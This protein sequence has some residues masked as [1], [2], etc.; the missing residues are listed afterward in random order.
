MAIHLETNLEGDFLVAKATG[1]D[2][3]LEEVQQYAS[4]VIEAARKSG[5]KKVLCDETELVYTIG[6]VDIYDL[7]KFISQHAP[8]VAR[9]AL[10][11]NP[12]QI[13]DAKFWETAI[14]NRGLHFRV[15]KDFDSAENWLKAE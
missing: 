5:C 7:A 3:S 12:D 1:R 4:A 15:F 13:D 9:V 8:S 14:A 11:I 10:V 2:D 6:T